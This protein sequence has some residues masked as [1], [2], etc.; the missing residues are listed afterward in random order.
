MRIP[1]TLLIA[2]SAFS[3]VGSAVADNVLQNGDFE[4]GGGWSG[5][6]DI[7]NLAADLS[8]LPVRP[9]RERGRPTVGDRHQVRP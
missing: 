9:R 1:S 4:S 2:T 7:Y 6:F 8:G 5:G 3:F